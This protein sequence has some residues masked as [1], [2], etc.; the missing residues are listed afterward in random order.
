MNQQQEFRDKV[1]ED[2]RLQIQ[3]AQLKE[4]S[5]LQGEQLKEYKALLDLYQALTS[6]ILEQM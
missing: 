2:K 5:R 3:V 4:M 1:M 6:Q